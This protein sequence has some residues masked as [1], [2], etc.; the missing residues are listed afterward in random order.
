MWLERFIQSKQLYLNK[1]GSL[2]DGQPMMFLSLNLHVSNN[3]MGRI[4]LQNLY[5]SQSLKLIKKQDKHYD[6]FNLDTI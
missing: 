6:Y 4:L 5:L 1:G 2:G 3:E